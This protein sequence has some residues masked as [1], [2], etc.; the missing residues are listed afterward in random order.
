[1]ATKTQHVEAAA[2]QLAWK[3]AGD[4]L[5]SERPILTLQNGLA[6]E[7]IL[8]RR[9][10]KVYGGS[11]LIPASYTETGTVIAGAAPKVAVFVMGRMPAGSDPQAE[12][13]AQLLR[14]IDWMVQVDDHVVAWKALKLLRSVRNG[15]D[16]M[17]IPDADVKQHLAAAVSEEAAG[18][19]AAAGIP[20]ARDAD[21][22]ADMS[23]FQVDPASGYTIGQQST[24]QSFARGAG[25]HE[26]D[27][28]N[29]EIVQLGRLHGVPTP[30]N[31]AIQ[32]TL[33]RAGLQGTAPGEIPADDVIAAARVTS[34]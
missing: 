22:T 13:I 6:A 9:F 33:G 4:Q 5:A 12:Q 27:Y 16:L 2:E 17:R 7:P 3:P 20:V 26:V 1:M 14:R 11:I 8:L 23:Q 32:T 29:G 28:L 21:R 30:V 24:W 15:L 19:L 25:S 34:A 31:T 10:S 18:A